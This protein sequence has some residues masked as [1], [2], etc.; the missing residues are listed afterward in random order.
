MALMTNIRLLPVAH[1]SFSTSKTWMFQA[2][3]LKAL[4]LTATVAVA[5]VKL[6]QAPG[7]Q[8]I[9]RDCVEQGRA[10]VV[11]VVTRGNIVE[12]G[13]ITRCLAQGINRRVNEP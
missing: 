12:V 4:F 2:V 8:V 6:E 3:V 5:Q 10:R 1:H 11:C 9:T 7:A 13:G